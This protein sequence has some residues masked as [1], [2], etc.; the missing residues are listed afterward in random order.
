MKRVLLVVLLIALLVSLSTG[1]FAKRHH[2]RRSSCAS[3]CAS[4]CGVNYNPCNPCAVRANP[5]N[6]CGGPGAWGWGGAKDV[7]VDATNMTVSTTPAITGAAAPATAYIEVSEF[8]ATGWAALAQ[9]TSMTGCWAGGGTYYI[10]YPVGAK[11]AA[12]GAYAWPRRVMKVG[13]GW[14]WASY[15]NPCGNPCNPCPRKRC[16]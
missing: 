8:G 14:V 4:P 2:A 5:C 3:P 9:R 13:N 6:P 11:D 12:V 1:A 10:A 7:W 15:C 16:W